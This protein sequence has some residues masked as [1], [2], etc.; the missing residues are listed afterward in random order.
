MPCCH[1]HVLLLFVLC[2]IVIQCGCQLKATY[3]LTYLFGIM[4]GAN[5]NAVQSTPVRV[6]QPLRV[7]RFHLQFFAHCNVALLF[8]FIR[9][10]QTQW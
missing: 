9:K 4:N 7:A 1:V 2:L 10:T 3:L 6:S 5:E 8:N